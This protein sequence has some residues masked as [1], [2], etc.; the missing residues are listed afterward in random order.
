MRRVI[1]EFLA[2]LAHQCSQIHQFTT[3]LWSPYG[4]KKARMRNRSPSM[5]HQKVKH[6]KFFRRQVNCLSAFLYK[7][8]NW[9]KCDV[10][11][12]Y[13]L[14]PFGLPKLCPADRGTQ[15]R[16]EFARSKRF[17]NV[18]VR[19][20]IECLYFVVFRVANAYHQD[21]KAPTGTPNRT[22]GL[23]SS[24]PRHLGV[25]KH[26]MKSGFPDQKHR[27]FTSPSLD[28]DEA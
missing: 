20:G 5:H 3:I 13:W 19:A 7:V 12:A 4:I 25:E 8:T 21:G 16:S 24:H 14:I 15:S 9:I 26:G 1:L 22:T 18:I 11:Y 10:P 28:S 27:L 23:N 17:R 6:L 2:K